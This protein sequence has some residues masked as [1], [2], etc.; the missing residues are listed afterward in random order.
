MPPQSYPLYENACGWNDLLPARAPEPPLSEDR[1]ADV[2]I[3]G[4]GY[5]GIAA[6]QRWAALRPDAQIALIDA[7]EI[8]DGSPG[9]NSGFL[10]E[11]TLANDARAD[12]LARL[13]KCNRLIMATMHK[14]RDAVFDGG[15]DCDIERAGTYRAAAGPAGRAALTRY[16]KFLDAAGLPAEHL[17]RAELARRIGTDYY[18]D[19]LYSPHCYLVQPAALIR[20]LARLLPKNVTLYENTPALG[21]ASAGSGWRVETPRATLAATSVL[22]ANNAF[23]KRLGIGKSRLST[24][25]TYAALT[26]PLDPNIV[27]GLGSEQTWGLLPAHR[28]GCTLRRTRDDRLLI[29]AHYG[30]EKERSN[31]AIARSLQQSLARRFPQ[32]GTV[33]FAS[34]W[35]GATGFTLNGAPVW[36]EFKRGLFA[37]AGCNGGGVVKGTLFGN[38]LA[39]RALGQSGPDVGALFGKASWMPPE[40]FRRLG[41]ALTSLLEE[42]RG[43]PEM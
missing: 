43:K 41:F 34:T 26:E 27:D 10:L 8:G 40:P 22:I 21:I 36:G 31:D 6:A 24:I 35:G 38:L 5:T 1:A 2:V 11:I 39:E 3:V 28:L 18:S 25:Y 16:A 7:T 13:E 37:S 32:L 15:I 30:Y 23:A 19:G 29:R 12:Q 42:R 14:L 4:A 9:R 17:K 20:G 33:P